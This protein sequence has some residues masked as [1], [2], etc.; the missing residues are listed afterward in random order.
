LAYKLKRILKFKSGGVV[1][2]DPY[3]KNDTDLVEEEKVLLESDLLIISAPHICY[4]D[5]K[6]DKPVI[7]IWNLRGNGSAI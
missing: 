3:V 7:D 2:A 5:L 6:I 4:K 1:T